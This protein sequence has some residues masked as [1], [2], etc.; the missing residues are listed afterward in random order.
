M[1][2][3]YTL[4]QTAALANRAYWE[5]WASECESLS[6]QQK[7]I[8]LGIF[9]HDGGNVADVVNRYVKDSAGDESRLEAL[10][11]AIFYYLEYMINAGESLAPYRDSPTAL[12]IMRLD[13]E[14]LLELLQKEL[15]RCVVLDDDGAN[16]ISGISAPYD[17]NLDFIERRHWRE[18]PDESF[19]SYW[20][21][22]RF[23]DTRIKGLWCKT[24]KFT[25]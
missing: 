9:V 6:L 21:K 3:Q 25:K 22:T 20:N 4:H 18:N 2:K 5:T 10:Q 11:W 8:N 19:S 24:R 16:V 17:K 15:L 13:K 12:R 1:G 14:E 23:W 7:I